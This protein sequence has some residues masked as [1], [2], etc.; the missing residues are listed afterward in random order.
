ML[1]AAIACI[2]AA[3]VALAVADTPPVPAT[4]TN[5]TFVPFLI[6]TGVDTNGDYV[7]EQPP[8]WMLAGPQTNLP[9]CTIIRV[10]CMDSLTNVVVSGAFTTTRPVAFVK[11]EVVEQ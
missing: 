10:Y 7:L 1:R 3:F 6:C 2:L 8:E 9:A 5:A 4:S 11:W